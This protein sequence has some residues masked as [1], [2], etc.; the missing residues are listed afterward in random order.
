[1]RYTMNA[2]VSIACIRV[3]Y[4]QLRTCASLHK[5]TTDRRTALVTPKSH[6]LQNQ[7]KSF[8]NDIIVIGLGDG[9]VSVATGEPEL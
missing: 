8:L 7:R 1:M 9:L 4:L 2:R 6:R 3:G 5:P